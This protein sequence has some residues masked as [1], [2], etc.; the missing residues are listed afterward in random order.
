MSVQKTGKIEEEQ[1][2]AAPHS[3]SE[4]QRLQNMDDSSPCPCHSGKAFKSCCK[5][6]LTNE[7]LP[8]H[9]EQLMRSRYTA[10]ALKQFQYIADTHYS[11]LDPINNA[12]TLQQDFQDIQWQHLRIISSQKSH[13]ESLQDSD[14]EGEVS[15]IAYY[16]IQGKLFALS[17]TSHFIK[18]D[19]K[20]LY[21]ADHSQSKVEKIKLSRNDTCFCESGKKFKKCCDGKLAQIR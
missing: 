5:P 4:E 21:D 2:K 8:S 18:P 14:S 7:S 16:A 13:H 12:E 17:E 11:K 19:G 6:Y 9:P 20:W 15:F 10:F 1:I 3:L